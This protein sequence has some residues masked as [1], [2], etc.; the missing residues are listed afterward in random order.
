[1]AQ[2]QGTATLAVPKEVPRAVNSKGPGE[3]DPENH[4]VFVKKRIFK[5]FFWAGFMNLLEAIVCSTVLQLGIYIYI[6]VSRMGH[7]FNDKLANI[8]GSRVSIE[9]PMDVIFL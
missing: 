4:Q 6:G 9:S 5:P 8:C 1:M 7:V 2:T 3:G